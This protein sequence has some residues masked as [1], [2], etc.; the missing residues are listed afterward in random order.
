M[1]LT[2]TILNS[3]R[4]KEWDEVALS[5]SHSTLFHTV[6]W[7]RL[8]EEQSNAEFLPLMFYKG[9]QLVAIYPIFV[10]KQGPIKVALSPLS[11]TYMLYLGPVI[12]DYDSLKQD[13]K[14]SMYIQIQQET[15]KY[16]FDTKRCKFARIK[17]SPDYMIHDL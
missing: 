7:L 9:T 8:V 12:A 3:S 15:D 17:S 4:E 14:E 16:I 1:A 6:K 11:K 13:K 2:I 10:K 5:S